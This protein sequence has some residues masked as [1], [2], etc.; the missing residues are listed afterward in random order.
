MKRKV[1]PLRLPSC[2]PLKI[3]YQSWITEEMITIRTKHGSIA[4][5][6]GTCKKVVQDCDCEKHKQMCLELTSLE[7]HQLPLF[8]RSTF[9]TIPSKWEKD[10]LFGVPPF[11]TDHNHNL[12]WKQDWLHKNTHIVHNTSLKKPVE[13]NY[14]YVYIFPCLYLDWTFSF[15]FQGRCFVPFHVSLSDIRDPQQRENIQSSYKGMIKTGSCETYSASQTCVLHCLVPRLGSNVMSIVMGYTT[16][17]AMSQIEELGMD[18]KSHTCATKFSE[19]TFRMVNK[20]RQ[21]LLSPKNCDT[22]QD[23]LRQINNADILRQIN[24]TQ[25]NH[26]SDDAYIE[27]DAYPDLKSFSYTLRIDVCTP[28]VDFRW[29]WKWHE[30]LT[31]EEW[32]AWNLLST[33]STTRAFGVLS[34]DNALVLPLWNMRALLAVKQDFLHNKLFSLPIVDW[35]QLDPIVHKKSL[36]DPAVEMF[37]PYLLPNLNKAVLTVK[38]DQWVK[39][40]DIPFNKLSALF[41]STFFIPDPFC[42]NNHNET[43]LT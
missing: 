7:N 28:F 9:T 13:K 22:P 17:N 35:I 5:L 33:N 6:L 12:K 16:S 23:V 43:P 38:R 24:D 18:R 25:R 32:L 26:T 2:G 11:L 34:T 21:L 14:K 27:S 20:R 29:V 15:F 40:S 19:S 30:D 37:R 8:V 4:D 41:A 36:L 42:I 3:H 1:C 10:E 39:W 31:L